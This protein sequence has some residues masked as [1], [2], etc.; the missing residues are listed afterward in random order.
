MLSADIVGQ[1]IR[2]MPGLGRLGEGQESCGQQKN[3]MLDPQGRSGDQG[4]DMSRV[5]GG[6]ANLAAARR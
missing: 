2:F 6:G 4:D 1:V 3:A 5:E